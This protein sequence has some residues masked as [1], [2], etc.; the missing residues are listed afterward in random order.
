MSDR[1]TK[2]ADAHGGGYLLLA[3]LPLIPVIV[4]ALYLEFFGIVMIL[5]VYKLISWRMS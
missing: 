5:D 3:L 4:F 2:L 1:L